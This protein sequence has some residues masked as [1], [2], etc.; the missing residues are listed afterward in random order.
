MSQNP[1]KALDRKRSAVGWK[2]KQ[3]E[4]SFRELH[5]IYLKCQTDADKARVLDA[6]IQATKD[7]TQ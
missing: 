4:K 1:V 2:R 7:Q 3:I 6:F 5:A